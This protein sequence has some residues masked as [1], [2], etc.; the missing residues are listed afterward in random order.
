VRLTARGKERVDAALADLLDRERD[1]L[2]GVSRTDQERLSGL[3]QR[4]LVPFDDG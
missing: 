3:L 2:R 4:L 1:L